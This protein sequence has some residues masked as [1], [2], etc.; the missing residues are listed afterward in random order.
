MWYNKNVG[1]R[2]KSARFLFFA[3]AILVSKIDK[4]RINV[5]KSPFRGSA[6][7]SRITLSAKKPMGLTP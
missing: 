4:P 7:A 1:A 5:K 3:N 6:A 2:R